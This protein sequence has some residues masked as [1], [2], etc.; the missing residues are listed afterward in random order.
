MAKKLTKFIL[1]ALLLGVI[2]GWAINASID[3]GTPA[4]AEQLKQIA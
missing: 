3:D 1:F 4:A 2:A